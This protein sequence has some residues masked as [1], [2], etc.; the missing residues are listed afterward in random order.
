VET[1]EYTFNSLDIFK[2]CVYSFKLNLNVQHLYEYCIEYEKNNK[3]RNKSGVGSFQSKDLDLN[4]SIIN[5]LANCFLKHAN[6]ISYN[7]Y[8][9]KNKLH[10]ANFWF[11][12]N[13]YKD[14]NLEH[15]HPGSILSGVYYVK[16]P[17]NS[18][19]LIFKNNS[20]RHLYFSDSSLIEYNT[21]NNTNYFLPPQENCL[22]IFPSWLM[23]YV[24]PNL[25]K[26]DRVSFSFNTQQQYEKYNCR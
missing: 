10:L 4:N 23:H 20:N 14:F 6:F 19:N 22:H 18:G 25:S 13:R 1:Q 3:S 12:I 5:V 8:K 11:N 21:L 7:K 17:N 15:D 16:T 24:E 2:T 26:E 9:I